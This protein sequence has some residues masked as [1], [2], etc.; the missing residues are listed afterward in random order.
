MKRVLAVGAVALALG[1]CAAG[2]YYDSYGSYGYDA[3]GN[4]VYAGPSYYGYDAAPYYSAPSVSLGYYYYD[5]DGHRQWHDG[6]ND[7][8][9]SRDDGHRGEWIGHENDRRESSSSRNDAANGRPRPSSEVVPPGS[10]S[11]P[12]PPNSGRVTGSNPIGQDPGAGP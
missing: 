5:N 8:R 11:G 3:Y 1:G 10:I 4:P 2:P 9:W 12:N 6:R 7:G